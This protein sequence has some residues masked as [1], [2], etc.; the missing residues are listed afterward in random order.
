MAILAADRPPAPLWQAAPV[1]S[2]VGPALRPA[3]VIR[4]ALFLLIVGNLGR[5]PIAGVGTDGAPILFN[6]VVVLGVL[7]AG[8]LAG[9]RA[10]AWRI[11]AP[12][13]LALAFAGVGGA[14]AILAVPRFGLSGME[15]AYSLAY[16]ARW[17]T[18]FGIYLVAINVLRKAD[19]ASVWG[20]L[21]AMILVFAVFGIIQSLFIP[22]F[23]QVVQPE[24]GWDLQGRRLVSTFLD[25][26]MAGGLIV[27][28]L[29]VV[30][31][32]TSA[33]AAVSPWKPVVL[34]TALVFTLSRGSLVAFVVGGVVILAARGL[35]RRLLRMV[36]VVAVLSLP[37]VPALLDFAR[38][39]NKFDV[40]AS[41]LDKLPLYLRAI[42][43][44]ADHP[45]VGVGFNTYGFV[46]RSYGWEARGVLR[47]GTDGGLLF[48]AVMTG[49]VG[50][51]LYIAMMGLVVLRCRRIWRDQAR[52]AEDRGLAIGV[53]AA[54]AAIVV[55]SIFANSLLLPL[56]ME[57]LW[58][59]WALT[60]V[61][62][63]PKRGRA[64][65][66]RGPAVVSFAPALRAGPP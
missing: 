53:A 27:I 62:A 21:E 15:L 56:I 49:L 36:A 46:Q 9:I 47:F 52:N 61:I 31:A 5:V 29:L 35:S 41:A 54:T 11:D 38:T 37:F 50:L 14:S 24:A 43:V 16:L 13:L 22:G 25:P 26:N 64:T 39:F 12:G 23:A 63:P 32:R 18:Y 7:A 34:V 55:H 44:F 48:I 30:A 19:V 42:A 40:G 45:V 6:D 17:L 3:S 66:T 4:A 33:G 60:L 65:V 1:R 20:A 10:G 8:L 2:I 28:G 59:L 51:A 58:V 57:P